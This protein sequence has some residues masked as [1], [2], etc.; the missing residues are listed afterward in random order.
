MS[1]K[2]ELRSTSTF[3][4][5]F[6]V[7]NTPELCFKRWETNAYYF[8]ANYLLLVGLGLLL[9]PLLGRSIFLCAVLFVLFHATF[10]IR[11]IKSKAYLALQRFK[12]R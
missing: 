1:L 7:P 9:Y 3:L 5:T 12:Q 8:A 4:G 2:L 10:K 6:K 11:T